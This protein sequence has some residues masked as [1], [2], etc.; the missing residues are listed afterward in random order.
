MPGPV[1]V[2]DSVFWFSHASFLA[3]SKDALC[4]D[5]EVA[6]M[7]PR[8]QCAFLITGCAAAIAISCASGGGGGGGGGGTATAG[9]GGGADGGILTV[10]PDVGADDPTDL[11]LAIVGDPTAGQALFQNVLSAC[12]VCHGDHGEGTVLGPSIVGASS[13]ELDGALTP[14][15]EHTGGIMPDF[16][17]QEFADLAAF[18][19]GG[20][21]TDDINSNGLDAGDADSNGLAACQN[22]CSDRSTA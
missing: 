18:L 5:R 20:A 10:N 19:D 16:T 21:A 8:L 9:P 14:G 12:F 7:M 15:S 6:R 3:I 1:Q 2:D 17:G 13:L 22:P 4:A 11:A